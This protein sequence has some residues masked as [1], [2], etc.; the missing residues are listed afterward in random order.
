MDLALTY[1]FAL[2]LR[3]VSDEHPDWGLESLAEELLVIARN[4]RKFLGLSE[5][6]TAFDPDKYPGTVVVATM[7]KAKGLEW[8]R[9]YLTSV[10]NYD[11]PSAQSYDSFVAEKWFVRDSLNLQAECLKQF[12]CGDGR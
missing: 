12:G 6:D 10:N 2:L 7:H 5:D 1:K 4:Q 8:D 11:F 3:D 9:V